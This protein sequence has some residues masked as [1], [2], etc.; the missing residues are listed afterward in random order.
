MQMTLAKPLPYRCDAMSTG[1][2]APL[3]LSSQT[4]AP[5]LTSS[6]IARLVNIGRFCHASLVETSSLI[7]KTGCLSAFGVTSTAKFGA[8]RLLLKTANST[9][10]KSSRR[11]SRHEALKVCWPPIIRTPPPSSPQYL[12]SSSCWFV[13]RSPGRRFDNTTTRNSLSLSSVFGKPLITSTS[14]WTLSKNREALEVRLRP[15]KRIVGSLLMA[16]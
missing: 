15:V 4:S 9:G 3:S 1:W 11:L 7:W 14:L 6:T 8:P 12:A 5:A 13:V 16:I 10:S 2:P